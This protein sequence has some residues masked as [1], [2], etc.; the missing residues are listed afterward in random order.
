MSSPSSV[1]GQ[2][3]NNLVAESD[4]EA[5]CEAIDRRLAS[6]RI[7][8]H[9]NA[10]QL[11][12]LLEAIGTNL[13]AHLERVV[14]PL[15][16]EAYHVYVHRCLK[17]GDDVTPTNNKAT[18]VEE[19]EFDEQEL[20]DEDALKRVQELR[21][22]VREQATKVQLVRDAVLEKAVDLA[23]RQVR[24]WMGP[25]E[26]EKVAESSV[27][28]NVLRSKVSEMQVSLS[29]MKE[30]LDKTLVALPG[31]L[32]SLQE[33]VTTIEESF[34]KKPMLS[35]TEQAII[36]RDNEGKSKKTPFGVHNDKDTAPEE[37]L[38]NLLRQD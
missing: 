26:P 12:V 5:A 14:Q 33:T 9:D 27:D 36:S 3:N 8:R 29:T 19:N 21:Q 24:V 6:T 1:A 37:Q 18:T 4:L 16:D 20:I 2:R 28:E 31:K 11:P 15:D 7:G 22:Q 17:G 35:Q 10:E 32:Q 23:E 25:N 38:A 34:K 13:K 30:A